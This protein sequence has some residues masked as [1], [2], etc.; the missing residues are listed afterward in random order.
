MPVTKKYQNASRDINQS[1]FVRVIPDTS[2]TLDI[3]SSAKSFSPVSGVKVN[4][5]TGSVRIVDQVVL[6]QECACGDVFV[7]ESLEI[8]FN[9]QRDN[10]AG[11]LAALEEAKRVMG[12]ALSEYNL[13][14]GLV[15]PSEAT[16]TQGESD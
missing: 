12:I 16:F 7:G 10:A 13:A 9:F 5:V 6:D 15:P 2:A 3:K 4:M 14:I 8:R 1:S 11:I